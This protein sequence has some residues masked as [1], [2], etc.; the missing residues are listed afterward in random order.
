MNHEQ[1]KAMYEAWV[2]IDDAENVLGGYLYGDNTS[3][4]DLQDIL[5]DLIER[6]MALSAILQEAFGE[7]VE[8][9]RGRIIARQR[10]EML[11]GE[12]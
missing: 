4:D 7:P 2:S 8:V 12:A 1:L 11:G 9:V 6:N 5:G 3:E 10:E